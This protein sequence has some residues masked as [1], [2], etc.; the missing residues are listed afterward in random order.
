MYSDY[1]GR[2]QAVVGPM[3]AF[4]PECYASP[5]AGK[6][7]PDLSLLYCTFHLRTIFS[8]QMFS[9]LEWVIMEDSPFAFV[10]DK[11]TRK[12]NNINGDDRPISRRYLATGR[13]VV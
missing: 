7:R 10:E 4:N 5:F 13:E 9:W 2:K 6:V 1:K 3:D 12:Y 8:A 11:L